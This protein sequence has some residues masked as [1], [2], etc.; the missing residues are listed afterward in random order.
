VG[1]E[2]LEVLGSDVLLVGITIAESFHQNVFRRIVEPAAPSAPY[3]L[4]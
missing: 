2:L 1:N 4:V 3:G